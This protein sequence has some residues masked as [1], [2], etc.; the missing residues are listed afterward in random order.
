[1]CGGLLVAAAPTRLAVLGY[2]LGR[3]LGYVGLGALAG[4]LGSALFSDPARGAASAVAAFLMAG[5]FVWIGFRLWRGKGPGH[6]RL[7]QVMTNAYAKMI[8]MGGFWTGLFSVF[9]PCGWLHSF[10]LGAATTGSA[11]RGAAFMAVFW[12]GT[13]P[14]LSATP[15][16]FQRF[17]RPFFRSMPKMAAV[18]MVMAGILTIAFRMIPSPE[19]QTASASQGGADQSCH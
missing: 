8:G 17:L 9:L 10:V 7:P 5:T 13:V 14:A 3:L 18:L 11:A 12:A 2:Q 1:M 6:L 4:T 16:V 19:R 15:W